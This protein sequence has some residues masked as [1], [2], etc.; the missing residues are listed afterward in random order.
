MRFHPTVDW[1]LAEKLFVLYPG[2][3]P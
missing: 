3:V 2:Q 1:L